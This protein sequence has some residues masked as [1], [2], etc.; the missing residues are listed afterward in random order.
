[1]YSEKK[2]KRKKKQKGGLTGSCQ[3]LC[4]CSED[5]G[6]GGGVNNLI[7]SMGYG[8]T[9]VLRLCMAEVGWMNV[10]SVPM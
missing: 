3:N 6:G 10:P 2:L 9:Y 8:P 5:E 4:G 1:M 7:T